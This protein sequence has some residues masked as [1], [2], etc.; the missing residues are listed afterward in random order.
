MYESLKMSKS[1]KLLKKPSFSRR[2]RTIAHNDK[3]FL[4]YFC[5]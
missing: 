1:G 2:C 3:Y 4:N 5:L